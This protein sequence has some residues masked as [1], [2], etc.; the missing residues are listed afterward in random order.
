MTASFSS[1]FDGFSVDLYAG[2]F[3]GSFD[4]ETT[5]ANDQ[6]LD[7]EA[8]FVV[9]ARVQGA[10]MKH[11]KNGDLQRVNLYGVAD[12]VRINSDVGIK[13]QTLRNAQ[14]TF[15]TGLLDDTDLKKADEGI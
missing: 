1:R 14:L 7:E 13:L 12:V 4:I 9:R 6:S 3:N 15:N 11:T 8:Y 5:D 2:R 10:Q